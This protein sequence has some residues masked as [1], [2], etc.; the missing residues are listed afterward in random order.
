LL[1]VY[2]RKRFFAITGERLP[3]SSCEP[4]A[5]QAALDAFMAELFPI[6][7]PARRPAPTRAPS[8]ADNEILERARSA[9][10]GEL[11][12]ALWAGRWQHRYG[13]QSEADLALCSML[14]F[15]AGGDAARVDALFRCSALS[16]EKWIDRADYR[17]WTLA[18]ATQ[19]D[20]Y[21]A[22]RV[23]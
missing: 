22:R 15:W 10:N 17:E 7:E 16:R 13:S 4:Q 12:S 8:L 20:V 1:E 19:G 11:F 2:C 14:S 3:D 5:R 6:V 21:D 18:K 9:R 23:A